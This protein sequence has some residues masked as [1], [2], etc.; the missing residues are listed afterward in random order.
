[1][2]EVAVE[3]RRGALFRVTVA[4]HPA[5]NFDEIRKVTIIALFSDDE[6]M[7]QLVLKGGNAINLVHKLSPRTSLDLDFSIEGDFAD[8][9]QAKVRM[10]RALKDR[11]DS[12]GFAVFDEKLQSKPRLKGPDERPWWGG[13][14][15]SFK[16]I[17]KAKLERLK[18]HHGRMQ[19]DALPVG[20]NQERTFFVDLSKNEFTKGKAAAKL[21][22]FTVYVYTLE[23][24]VIEKL[25]AI[26][27]QMTE[28]P[29]KG[30]RT[31]RARDFFDIHLILTKTQ[32]DLRASDNV[33]LMRNIF[34]VKQVPLYLLENIPAYREF[35]R[36]DWP[37]VTAAVGIKI[38]EYDYYFDFVVA[39]VKRL[40]AF[41]I[42][43][44]PG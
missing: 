12:A 31:A 36:P 44:P 5:M 35:H 21:D 19:I 24:L 37:A 20:P 25:R 15:L 1:M 17:D 26:C 27:Q 28:Y 39:E 9:E 30:I 2:H 40:E 3:G 41:W 6:L 18:G 14:E 22:Y 32:M 33:Q 10:F 7:K 42:E 38:E 8:F 4:F 23:M 43:E 34:E 11:F 16:L 13:Y 29:F